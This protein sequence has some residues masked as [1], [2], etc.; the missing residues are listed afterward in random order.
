M[1]F[2]PKYPV[3][4]KDTPIGFKTILQG[5]RE[6]QQENVSSLSDRSLHLV[7]KWL[8]AWKQT[9]IHVCHHVNGT[10]TGMPNSLDKLACLIR[11]AGK[12]VCT[13]AQLLLDL[14]HFC[15][16]GVPIRLVGGESPREGRVELHMSGQ[17]GTVCDD[18]WT[19]RD[20]EVVCRQ[21]GYRCVNLL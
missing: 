21:L 15:F 9:D 7:H 12:R 3:I 16:S 13:V 19:D 14:L 18:G 2:E 8:H 17:W 20:A 10:R 1:V 4:T 5:Q 11:F 6:I